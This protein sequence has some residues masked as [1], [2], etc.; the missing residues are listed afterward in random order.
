MKRLF[1]II[2]GVVP[3]ICGAQL[4]YR[5]AYAWPVNDLFPLTA[6]PGVEIA[7]SVMA[8]MVV[9][10]GPGG[11]SAWGGPGLAWNMPQ[12]RNTLIKPVVGAGLVVRL[13]GLWT[14]VKPSGLYICAG[15]RL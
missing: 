6:A 5:L 9:G 7:P 3:A 1:L 14:T 4:T 10:I 12:W 11:E 13:D 15:F 2:L 8:E